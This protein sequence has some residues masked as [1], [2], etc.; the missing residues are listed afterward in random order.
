MEKF[1]SIDSQSF[2]VFFSSLVM[3]SDHVLIAFFLE[4]A[5]ILA[6]R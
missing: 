3:F 5:K 1:V 6:P 2:Q 4:F